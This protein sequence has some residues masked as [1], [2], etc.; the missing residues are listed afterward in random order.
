M[1]Q[2]SINYFDPLVFK[3][4]KEILDSNINVVNLKLLKLN[5]KFE[6]DLINIRIRTD[7]TFDKL[8][9]KYC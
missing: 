7:K 4:F 8:Q 9:N 1:Q 3:N 6:L 2:K 5:T